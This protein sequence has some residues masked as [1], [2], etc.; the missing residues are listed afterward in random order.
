MA[1]D[2]L[3]RLRAS[4]PLREADFRIEAGLE[5]RGDPGLLRVVLENL[6]SNAWKYSSKREVAR[7]E[8]GSMDH[9]E[10]MRTFFIRDNGAG[11]DTQ[12][13]GKLFAPFQRLHSDEEF[14]GTGVGLAT[15][16][17]IIHRHSG[18]I[19]ARAEVEK[20]ATFYFTLP[21]WCGGCG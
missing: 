12:L 18:L 14:S 9:E 1:S 6:L 16:Q 5:A 19:W 2:L 7:I 17:R 13:A 8:F 11:F 15:V 21:R 20:G 4:D 3:G 10:G